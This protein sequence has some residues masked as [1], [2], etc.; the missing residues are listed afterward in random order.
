MDRWMGAWMDGWMDG[1]M[2]GWMDGWTDGRMD[3]WTDG[4]CAKLVC[5]TDGR[6]DGLTDGRMD[7]RMDG[8][9]N[10]WMGGWMDGEGEGIHAGLM[11]ALGHL[12]RPMSD[13]SGTC[14]HTFRPSLTRVVALKAAL[15]RHQLLAEPH[16]GQLGAPAVGDEHV[17][18]L[19]A[20]CGVW[21][22]RRKAR[23]R[24]WTRSIPPSIRACMHSSIQPASHPDIQPAAHDPSQ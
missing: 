13:G 22:R 19:A 11:Q 15:L 21:K 12:P 16:V 8:W 2:G 17:V 23:I 10:G 5:R 6:M 14:V 9:M 20:G 1:W 3:G 7:G 4:R 18:G 24:A